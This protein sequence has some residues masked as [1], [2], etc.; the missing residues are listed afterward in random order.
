MTLNTGSTVSHSLTFPCNKLHEITLKKRFLWEPE[1]TN[2]QSFKFHK[3]K[4]DAWRFSPVFPQFKWN[5]KFFFSG[6]HKKLSGV[7]TY[8]WLHLP[9]LKS[10]NKNAIRPKISGNPGLKYSST[11]FLSTVVYGRPLPTTKTRQWGRGCC[12]QATC[13]LCRSAGL[14]RESARRLAQQKQTKTISF[15]VGITAVAS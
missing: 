15:Q 13:L 9:P 14:R 4:S 2:F 3:M 11:R 10:V 5:L 1:K 12:T 8:N 6:S 7:I